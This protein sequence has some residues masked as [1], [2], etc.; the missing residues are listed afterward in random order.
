MTRWQDDIRDTADALTEPSIHREPIHEWDR[1][2]HR[3]TRHHKTIQPG[4][5]TQLYQAVTPTTATAG[6]ETTSAGKP[7]SRPP[8]A[9]EALSVHDEI[10]TNVRRWCASLGLPPRTTPESNIRALT[11]KAMSFDEDTALVLLTELRRWH[12]WCLVMTG[13]QHIRRLRNTTCPKPGC[14]KT[15]T[16]RINLTTTTALC[17]N[18]G[19]HWSEEDGTLTAL[20]THVTNQAPARADA[21]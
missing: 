4:L 5:L 10:S 16:L 7:K 13:W 17:R 6:S 18:C 8:L 2:R 19:G 11:A 21:A 12:R 15:D 9:I 20:I 14:G 1:H 3:R